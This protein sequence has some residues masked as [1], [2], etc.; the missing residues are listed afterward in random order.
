MLGDLHFLVALVLHRVEIVLLRLQGMLFL[1]QL[2]LQLLHYLVFFDVAPSD[3]E[4]HYLFCFSV[5]LLDL[6][7]QSLLLFQLVFH[8][9]I[10]R[11]FF[12]LRE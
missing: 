12:L 10:V 8:Q 1:S 9:L 2:L 7:E 11:H 5:I 4:G 3:A 6:R